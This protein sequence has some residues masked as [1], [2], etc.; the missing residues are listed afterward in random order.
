MIEGINFRPYPGEQNFSTPLRFSM[1]YYLICRSRGQEFMRTPPGVEHSV[2]VNT[3]ERIAALWA[4]WLR[5]ARRLRAYISRHAR[6]FVPTLSPLG[7]MPGGIVRY[8]GLG[9]TL[10]AMTIFVVVF[11]LYTFQLHNDLGTHAEDL[12]IMD[13][14]LWNTA[15]G[16]FWQETICNSISDTNCLVGTSRWA[17]HF[18]P[19]MLALVPLYWLIP[20]PHMLQFVQVAGVS[21]GALPAYWL[22]SRRFQNIGAGVVV[23]SVFLL[24]PAIRSAIVDDFHMVALAAPL[25][26]FAVY[27]LYARQDRG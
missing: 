2:F 5:E 11:T 12:G 17:I 9:I 24:M 21:L 16:H 1:L 7:P 19:L 26:M 15:H 14:V 27:F 22:G 8:I 13:Q 10:A 4:A 23:A 25:L 3:R 6:V 20:G 18:E